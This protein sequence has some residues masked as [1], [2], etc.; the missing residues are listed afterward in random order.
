M[1]DGISNALLPE[2]SPQEGKKKPDLKER[3]LGAEEVPAFLLQLSQELKDSTLK[4]GTTQSKE[5]QDFSQDSDSDKTLE[6]KKESSSPYTTA[7]TDLPLL[8]KSK[9]NSEVLMNSPLIPSKGIKESRGETRSLEK[10]ADASLDVSEPSIE[11]LK[12]NKFDFSDADIQPASEKLSSEIKN[13]E[14]RR[15]LE[16]PQKTTESKGSINTFSENAQNIQNLS[17]FTTQKT[18]ERPK[19][20][21]ESKLNFDRPMRAP[22]VSSEDFLASIQKPPLVTSRVDERSVYELNGDSLE[23]KQGSPKIHKKVDDE[24]GTLFESNKGLSARMGFETQEIVQHPVQFHFNSSD[25]G[26]DSTHAKEVTGYVVPGAMT[27]ERLSS[28]S[29]M[30]LSSMIKDLKANGDGEIRVRL[31]PENLG[32]LKLKV[33]TQGS[34]VGIQ[35]IASDPKAKAVIEESLSH[36]KEKLGTHQLTLARAEILTQPH[37]ISMNAQDGLNNNFLDNNQMHSGSQ[38]GFEAYQGNEDGSNKRNRFGD[39][40][41]MSTEGSRIGLSRP[42]STST[43]QSLGSGRLNIMA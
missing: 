39:E 22:V 14:L 34:Q 37:S 3:D 26:K 15:L 41:E 35:V 7:E 20:K 33:Q 2:I 36:L 25:F 40:V 31:N 28:E 19:Y 43:A 10:V 29:L 17:Q 12:L 16:E 24:E 5:A 6:V 38:R 11:K 42:M 4:E 8:S 30:G 27:Q 18:E 13:S 21:E 23:L 1:I 32:E 9:D